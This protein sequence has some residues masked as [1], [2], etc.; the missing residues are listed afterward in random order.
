M[1][2]L[3]SSLPTIFSALGY[4]A[5]CSTVGRCVVRLHKSFVILCTKCSSGS[6]WF[7]RCEHCAWHP[8]IT[9]R[10]LLS[11]CHSRNKYFTGLDLLCRWH[12]ADAITTIAL[13]IVVLRVQQDLFCL[14]PGVRHMPLLCSFHLVFLFKVIQCCT[15]HTAFMFFL[16]RSHR[17]SKSS[18]AAV[19]CLIRS[20]IFHRLSPLSR[21]SLSLSFRLHP[22]HLRCVLSWHVGLERLHFNISVCYFACRLVHWRC[23][24]SPMISVM[25]SYQWQY[26][27]FKYHVALLRSYFLL[28]SRAHVALSR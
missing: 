3:F 22:L 7:G 6:M 26:V 10:I 1:P 19:C 18:H 15:W 9:G 25:L 20:Y 11:I 23:V 8:S 17:A 4:S 5:L 2:T 13:L 27:Q 21:S 16:P 28:R 24:C 12:V 14:L